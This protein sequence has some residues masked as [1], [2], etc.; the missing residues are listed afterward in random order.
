M[1]SLYK[2]ISF[3][4]A[5][6]ISA[7]SCT[8]LDSTNFS[9]VANSNFWQTPE[10]IA[11]GIAPAYTA[12]QTIPNHGSNN[13]FWQAIE[14]SSDEVITPT[15]GGQ[16]ADG[17]QW[18]SLWQHS[19][20][21]DNPYI[22]TAWVNLFTPIGKINF[23]LSIVNSLPE[24][25][26]NL[27]AIVA[28]LKVLRAYV[29][30]LA[31]DAFG[32]VPLVTDYE[33]D[34]QSVTNTP[35]AEIFQFVENELK[36][37][38]PLLNPSVNKST[39]GRVT[40]WFGHFLLAKLYLNSKVYNGTSHMAECI[41]QCDSVIMSGKYTLLANYYDN[42]APDNSRL[43]SEGN[44]NIFVIPFENGFIA[45]NEN[46][47]MT[48][49]GGNQPTFQMLQSPWDGFCT[50]ADF[51]N[52]FDTTSVYSASGNNTFRTFLDARSGQYLV[53]QQFVTPF[54]FPPD[55]N[56]LY[57]TTDLS[58]FAKEVSSGDNLSYN[59]EIPVFSSPEDEFLM[60]GVR[61]IK[62]YPEPNIPYDQS[63]DLVL[64]RYADI[65]LMKAEAQIRAGAVTDALD[66]VNRVRRRAYG[67]SDHD[68]SGG[69]L[70]LDNIL[71]E[72][73]RELAWE[74]WRRQDLIRYEVEAGTVSKY[75]GAARSAGKLAD[76]DTHFQIFPIPAPQMIANPNLEQNPGYQ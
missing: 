50:A 40:K 58:L 31:M 5:F 21:K 65:L 22:N 64:F 60:A 8:R 52:K 15:R 20:T 3:A 19:Y 12:L 27:D 9:T 29:Y 10:Q 17:G 53:G 73:G 47:W 11:A 76:P 55:K 38:V 67:N 35:R 28:E 63:N 59:P 26:S 44:E 42:F 66:L 7:T 37:N 72:R 43:S 57:H 68:W 56:V 39:Y 36:E 2:K 54:T 74:G 49:D 18:Q 75:F 30:F 71:D 41:S 62:Y 69:D 61:N 23:I 34:P 6:L 13:G 45:G 4:A 24:K 70:T 25:P 14:C 33:T 16:W 51:Y 48:L 1:K 32:N 46:A